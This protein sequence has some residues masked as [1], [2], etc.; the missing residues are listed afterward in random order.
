MNGREELQVL[1]A[2]TTHPVY[3]ATVK[4][5]LDVLLCGVVF[6]FVENHAQRVKPNLLGGRIISSIKNSGTPCDNFKTWLVLQG[7]SHEE[8]YSLG[9]TALI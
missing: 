8:K 7:H 3:L 2:R 1:E 6:P 9:S 4:M 5:K